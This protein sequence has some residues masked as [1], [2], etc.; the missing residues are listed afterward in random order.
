[1]RKNNTDLKIYNLLRVSFYILILNFIYSCNPEVNINSVN[2]NQ[3][4]KETSLYLKQH[5]QNPINWQRWTNSIFDVSKELD[6]LIVISIGYSSCHWCHVMEDETFANDSI[7]SVMNENFI[8]IKVD[9]EENP[10]VDQAYMLSLI[11]I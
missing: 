4:N 7:A 9:R 5:A 11:H 1:M 10:D 6:K 3:L 2:K 8:N